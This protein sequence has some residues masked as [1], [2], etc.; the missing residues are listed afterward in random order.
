[1]GK[2]LADKFSKKSA[3][4]VRDFINDFIKKDLI[5]LNKN[6]KALNKMFKFQK[7]KNLIKDTISLVNRIN[8]NISKLE[9]RAKL[10]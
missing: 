4:S 6:I 2:I 5:S 3:F 1:M 8:T 10:D 7:D 9:N